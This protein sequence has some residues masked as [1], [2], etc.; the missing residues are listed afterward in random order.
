MTKP[1]SNRLGMY[2]D[3]RTILDAAL[4]NGGGTYA[5]ETH[6]QAIHWRQRVYRFRKLYAETVGL[7]RESEYDC[8]VIPRVPP[9]SSTCYLQLRK[10]VGIFMPSNES[11]DIIFDE[12]P[13][14]EEAEAIARRLG[15]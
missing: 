12:D 13:L 8:I 2:Q 4:A 11:A 7:T 1:R 9:E 15:L 6:G 5:C 14:L 3:V 10:Q